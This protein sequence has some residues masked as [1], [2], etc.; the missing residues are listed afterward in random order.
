MNEN[1][2]IDLN[3]IVSIHEFRL[4]FTLN[5][6]PI[7]YEPITTTTIQRQKDFFE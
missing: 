5:E 1:G 2:P 7:E 3:R 6:Y 4:L